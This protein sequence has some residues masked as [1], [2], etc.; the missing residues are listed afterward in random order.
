MLVWPK[1]SSEVA[2]GALVSTD[3]TRVTLLGSNM[4]PLKWRFSLESSGIVIDVSDV[5]IYSLAS[6]WVW[7]FKLENVQSADS[8][9]NEVEDKL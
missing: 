7:V 1:D 3:D 5:Q 4:G 8:P 2:L 6:D 9:H